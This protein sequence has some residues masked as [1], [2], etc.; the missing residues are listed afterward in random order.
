[1]L[2]ESSVRL[3][4]YY[5][6]F[7]IRHK[8]DGDELADEFPAMMD[9]AKLHLK[10]GNW[11]KLIDMAEALTGFMEKR[12]YWNDA[13]WL[14]SA[15]L[16]GV[17]K[18]WFT[19]LKNDWYWHKKISLLHKLGYISIQQGYFEDAENYLTESLQIAEEIRNRNLQLRISNTLFLL[20]R[21]QGDSGKAQIYLEKGR[22]PTIDPASEP[23]ADLSQNTIPEP[24]TLNKEEIL[25]RLETARKEDDLSKEADALGDLGLI[26]LHDGNPREAQGLYE[27]AISLYEAIQK[28]DEEHLAWQGLGK[29][30]AALG[31]YEV[32]HDALEKAVQFHTKAGSRFNLLDALMDQGGI[33]IEE[34]KLDQ[35]EACFQ[36]ASEIA[37]DLESLSQFAIVLFHKGL[38]C[39]KRG[40]LEGAVREYEQFLGAAEESQHR[41]LIGVACHALG[42]ILIQIGK[43]DRARPVL[44]RK[45]EISRLF[46]RKSEEADALRALGE[47]DAWSGSAD[48]AASLLRDA[49]GLYNELGDSAGKGRS[50]FS[51]AHLQFGEGHIAEAWEQTEQLGSLF[52]QSNRDELLPLM[53]TM[54]ELFIELPEYEERARA[55]QTSVIVSEQD[56]RV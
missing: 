41:K 21:M 32:A 5:L 54:L 12:G 38:I 14:Y 15:A 8:A 9:S 18:R 19:I 55:F 29:A 1:M 20:S 37:I 47:I 34:M 17:E 13:L 48:S 22:P 52:D 10:H 6:A 7:A 44:S 31:K 40:D 27:N 28:P 3:A 35:A 42:S 16:D 45:L 30:L 43:Y 26:A 39:E 50:L 46:N 24:N 51:M 23:P 36:Q 25:I 56:G 53:Q 11:G 2:Q 4:E 33:Y 49:L